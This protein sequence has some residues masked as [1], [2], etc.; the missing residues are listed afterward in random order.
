[1]AIA[2]R[3]CGNENPEGA[4]YC[5]YC[6]A[7]LQQATPPLAAYPQPAQ[8]PNAAP[9]QPQ[10]QGGYQPPA[11]GVPGYQQSYGQPYG[12]AFQPQAPAP[13]PARPAY[14]PVV[15]A[16]AATA[17][18]KDPSTG[19]LLEMLPGFFGFLGIGRL[20]AGE[21]GL[22]VGLLLGYWAIWFVSWILIIITAG[23][24]AICLG[25]LLFVLYF[26][27]P[28]T[29]GILLQ[30]KLKLQQQLPVSTVQPF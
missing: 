5:Q 13:M 18:Y 16:A 10:P 26:A 17:G 20:W 22:G 29:S 7:G 11:S 30:K 8:P 6:G 24:L 14:P 12:G 3:T 28:I 9:A 23:I 25:P 2:C 15:V 27:A 21:V 4:A 1:M 19:L